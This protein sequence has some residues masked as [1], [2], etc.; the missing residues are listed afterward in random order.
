ARGARAM[1]PMRLVFLLVLVA[2]CGGDDGGEPGP[3]AAVAAE[4]KVFVVRH[5]EATTDPTD[6]GLT[7]AGQARA[8]SLAAM[9]AD[10]HL[11]AVYSS[12]YRR[13]KDTAMPAAAGAG[14]TVQVKMVGASSTAYAA[15]L[16]ATVMQ[17]PSQHA[18]LIVGHS[19]TVPE[20]V[21]ALS[22]TAVPAIAETEYNRLYI[23][24]L[25]ADGPHLESTTY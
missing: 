14:L 6:P 4:T 17:N 9:L 16:A 5:A 3:D 7:A 1:T 10:D 23:V 22:G 18:V 13:T 8:D 15:D 24:T 19:N 20:T 11:A 21:K 25:A 2:A 12:Q